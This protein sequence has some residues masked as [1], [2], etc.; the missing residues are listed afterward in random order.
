MV[1]LHDKGLVSLDNLIEIKVAQDP[2]NKDKT[3]LIFYYHGGETTIIDMPSEI[4][5]S[6][7]LRTMQRLINDNI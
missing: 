4:S 3:N 6:V 7:A 5:A 1:Y 2:F